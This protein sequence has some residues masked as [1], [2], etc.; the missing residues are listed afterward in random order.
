MRNNEN[1]GTTRNADVEMMNRVLEG[2]ALRGHLR[3]LQMERDDF[4]LMNPPVEDKRDRLIPL[5]WLVVT[6]NSKRLA[7]LREEH[8]PRFLGNSDSGYLEH[9][10]NCLD[11]DVIMIDRE[12]DMECFACHR[13][14]LME[15]SDEDYSERLKTLEDLEDAIHHLF[16]ES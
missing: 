5:R 3:D 8:M 4:E 12:H 9:C 13:Y 10:S 15:E 2:N 7:A 1:K 6:E 11:E 14:F 16:N